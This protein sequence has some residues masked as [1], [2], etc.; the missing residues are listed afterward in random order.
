ML[1]ISFSFIAEATRFERV[2]QLPK[3]CV[4]P[5]HYAPKWPLLR[6]TTPC[7]HTNNKLQFTIHNKPIYK[8]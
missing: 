2:I 6:F 4:F 7:G 5:L 1:C 3:S 8:H